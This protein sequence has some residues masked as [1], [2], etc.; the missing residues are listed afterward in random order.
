[1][2]FSSVPFGPCIFSTF[3]SDLTATFGGIFIGF[4]ANLDILPP[5]HIT[6]NISPPIF[7]FLAALFDITP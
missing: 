7:A 1:M 2:A 5:H 4:L 6:H 3:D